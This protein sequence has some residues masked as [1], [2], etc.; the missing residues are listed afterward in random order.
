MNEEPATPLDWLWQEL[1]RRFGREIAD[2]LHRGFLEQQRSY[3]QR[4]EQVR[5]A[6]RTAR[7]SSKR[8]LRPL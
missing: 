1:A 6:R 7:L 4:R 5:R 3:Q 8:E 2:D